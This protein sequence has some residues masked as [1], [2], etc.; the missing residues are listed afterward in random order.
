MDLRLVTVGLLLGLAVHAQDAP[1]T[2]EVA[3][4]KPNR[5]GPGRGGIRTDPGLL[6]ATNVTMKTL[7][8]FA[9]SVREYQISGPDWI[10]SERYDITAKSEES[11]TV[12]QRRRMLRAL[13]RD[14]FQLTEHRTT[15]E[16]PV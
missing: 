10:N 11:A 8:R 12:E 14:R 4:I 3:S 1:L 6:S 16:L 9:Y 7:I 15:K 2:F 13:L 5:S